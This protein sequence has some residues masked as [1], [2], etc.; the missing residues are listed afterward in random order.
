MLNARERERYARQMT[1]LGVN[2]QELLKNSHV[3]IAGVGGLGSP[4]ALY[5]A[6]AGIGTMTLADYDSVE[7]SNLNRQI[8]HWEGDIGRLKVES[9][10]EKLKNLNPE[11]EIRT[12]DTR[13]DET[14]AYM[15]MGDAD[16]LVDAMDN[17]LI[18]YSLNHI[19]AIKQIPLV[20]GAV[21]GFSGQVA[22]LFPGKTACLRCI[23]PHPPPEEPVPIIGV[24]A[25][26]IGLIEANEVI[27]Y[28]TGAGPKHE[29]R[30]LLWDGTRSELET[31]YV[32]R[33]PAC[34]ECGTGM[35]DPEKR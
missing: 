21:K 19:A 13:I 4:V 27:R 31:I 25:G 22:T 29:T 20:H 35:N 10:Q 3:F 15:V 26:I 1:L 14:N 8:L 28:L 6:A 23:F 16:I 24:T 7:R 34:S 2:G 5:L 32:E 33:D 12:L 18:R 17:Y 30:L 9:A 11:I